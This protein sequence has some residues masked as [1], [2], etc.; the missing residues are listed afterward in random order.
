MLYLNMKVGRVDPRV[1]SQDHDGPD[2][3]R[4]IAVFLLIIALTDLLMTH[5]L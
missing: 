2:W 4:W 1:N 5:L 3:D